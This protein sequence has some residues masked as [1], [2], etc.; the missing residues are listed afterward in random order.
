MSSNELFL[1]DNVS[2]YS[3]CKWSIIKTKGKKPTS[4]YAHSMLYLSKVIIIFGG[5]SSETLND[6]WAIHLDSK[7]KIWE[8]VKLKGEP[9]C[10][11]MYH[12]TSICMEGKSKGMIIIYGGRNA[13]DQ[14]LND[15]WGLFQHRE[16]PWEWVNIFIYTYRS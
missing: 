15:L 9:P 4:R 10:P 6:L 16:G 3:S 12:T 11:R 5:F 13:A 8:K 14:A 1:L 7:E 2:Y